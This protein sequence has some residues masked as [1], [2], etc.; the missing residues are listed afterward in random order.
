MREVAGGCGGWRLI[1]LDAAISGRADVG[2]LFKGDGFHF[3]GRGLE[4]VAG[5][6]SR[7]I[8]KNIAASH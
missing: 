4:L 7:Y 8:E 5:I 3:T 6:E 1:D 2:G